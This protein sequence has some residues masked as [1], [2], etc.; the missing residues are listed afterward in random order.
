M[1]FQPLRRET[2]HV[3][4]YMLTLKSLVEAREGRH[5]LHFFHL[6]YFSSASATN[7]LGLLLVDVLVK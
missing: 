2:H 1:L 4:A 7:D 5:K 6:P 3:K